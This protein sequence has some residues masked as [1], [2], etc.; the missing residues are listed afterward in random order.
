MQFSSIIFSRSGD[1][2]KS[3]VLMRSC[4]LRR[5]RI[6]KFGRDCENNC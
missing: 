6:F 2:E 5:S 3:G 1:P 4:E